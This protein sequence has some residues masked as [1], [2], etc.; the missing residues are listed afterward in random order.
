M[1]LNVVKPYEEI[2]K[3]LVKNI[4]MSKR[5]ILQE[6]LIIFLEKK[7]KELKLQIYE[8]SNKYGVSSIEE[9][10]NLY[11]EGLIEEKVSW[12]DYQRLDHLEFKKEQ[13]ETILKEIK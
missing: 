7:L 13:I 2:L 11:K 3:L 6:S 9:F 4:G 1:R 10:D 8:I 5:E 12:K